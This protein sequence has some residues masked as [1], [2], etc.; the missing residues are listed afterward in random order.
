VS[1]VVRGVLCVV[2]LMAMAPVLDQRAAAAIAVPDVTLR[3]P[4]FPQG[5]TGGDAPFNCGPAVVAA[6]VTYS[7]VAAPS[8]ADVRATLGHRGATNIGEWAW[9]LDAYGVPYTV[10]WTREEFDDALRAGK[11]IVV[12]VWMADLSYGP[13]L[14][15]PGASPAGQVGRYVRYGAGHAL[16]VVGI[17][18]GG[19]NYLVHDPNVFDGGV[20]RYADGTPKGQYRRYSADELWGSVARYA[21]G[22]GLAVSPPAPPAPIS[23]PHPFELPWHPLRAALGLHG[24]T[25]TIRQLI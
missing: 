14:N 15:Q 19:H 11:A 25:A 22:R 4:Y 2:V 13:D 16:L 23:I 6:A 1:S 21:G 9:L 10:T 24:Y 7:G 3:A 5:G 8:V 12:A 20:Y 18:D 17:A